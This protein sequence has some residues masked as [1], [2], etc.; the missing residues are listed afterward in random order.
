MTPY[1][2]QFCHDEDLWFKSERAARK[3][4]LYTPRKHWESRSEMVYSCVTYERRKKEERR[5]EKLE[6]MER[7]R[8]KKE[9]MIQ[10]WAD[11]PEAEKEIERKVHWEE[12]VN[13]WTGKINMWHAAGAISEDRK[14]G[15]LKEWIE[16]DCNVS[17][18]RMIIVMTRKWS[19]EPSMAEN[20]WKQYGI[21]EKDP[22]VSSDWICK[23]CTS[24]YRYP[25]GIAIQKHYEVQHPEIKPL[26]Y[27]PSW[28]PDP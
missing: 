20:L 10:R 3:H 17:D 28:E 27:D 1:E 16:R 23:I 19:K 4:F 2:C 22:K 24:G 12:Q 5:K 14:E 11:M 9:E 26:E 7:D 21:V 25:S 6:E 18:E 13:Y 15:M 8:K